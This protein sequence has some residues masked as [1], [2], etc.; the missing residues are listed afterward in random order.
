MSGH[1]HDEA[2]GGHAHGPTASSEVVERALNA[3]P[4][5]RLL[6]AAQARAGLPEDEGSRFAYEEWRVACAPRATGTDQVAAAIPGGQA[7]PADPVRPRGL[8]AD[9]S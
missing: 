9:Q 3:H 8:L 2:H 7:G 1:S 4:L 5:G 6:D